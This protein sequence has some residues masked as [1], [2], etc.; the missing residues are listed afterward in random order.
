MRFAD[1]TKEGI[2][3]CQSVIETCLCMEGQPR[4]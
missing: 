3:L 2:V 4:P 1:G